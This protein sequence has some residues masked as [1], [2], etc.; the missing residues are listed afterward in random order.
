VKIARTHR[1]K[2][3]YKSLRDD[4][5]GKLKKQLRFLIENVRHPSLRTKKI[6]GT[7]GIWEARVDKGHRFTFEILEDTIILRNIGNRD[8]VLK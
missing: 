7:I 3:A 5:K 4:V 2:R 6:K 8:E 1:F